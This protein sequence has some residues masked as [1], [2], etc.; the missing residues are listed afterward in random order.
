MASNR[1]ES[2]W[3]LVIKKA[4]LI[5]FREPTP[6]DIVQNGTEFIGLNH[7]LVKKII[8]GLPAFAGIVQ[9]DSTNNPSAAAKI[10]KLEETKNI[11]HGM[12]VS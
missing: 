8:Q 2:A 10:K 9:Q 4:N 6:D 7:P 11:W 5:R 12:I 3:N 1:I